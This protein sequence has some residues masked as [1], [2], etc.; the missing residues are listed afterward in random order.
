[1]HVA[2]AAP[3][4]LDTPNPDLTRP[5]H[6]RLLA[7]V[8][9]TGSFALSPWPGYTLPRMRL[10]PFYLNQPVWQQIQWLRGNVTARSR[11][12]WFAAVFQGQRPGPVRRHHLRNFDE[13]SIPQPRHLRTRYPRRRPSLNPNRRC[14][15]KAS[16]PRFRR[17]SRPWKSSTCGV[18]ATERRSDALW[19]QPHLVEQRRRFSLGPRLELRSQDTLAQAIL[20]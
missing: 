12:I 19:R 15:R 1:M 17:R 13:P 16:R 6:T 14:E 5:D 2:C 10:D 3:A 9:S 11:T 18:A 7:C 4:R 8:R 20:A